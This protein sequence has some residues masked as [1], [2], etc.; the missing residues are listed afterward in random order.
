MTE[1]REGQRHED[2]IKRRTE[3]WGQDTGEDTYMRTG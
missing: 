3:T 1:Y 2:R